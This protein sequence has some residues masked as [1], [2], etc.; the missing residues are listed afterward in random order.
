MVDRP[1]KT[2]K[3]LTNLREPIN[4][5]A[6]ALKKAKLGEYKKPDTLMDEYSKAWSILQEQLASFKGY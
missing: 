1:H 5:S 6:T 4:Y 2:V 3:S